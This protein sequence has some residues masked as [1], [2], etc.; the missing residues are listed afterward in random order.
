MQEPVLDHDPMSWA[1]LQIA[2]MPVPGT[3][4]MLSMLLVTTSKSD[5]LLD[6][7]VRLTNS[8]CLLCILH[9]QLVT[10]RRQECLAVTACFM[11]A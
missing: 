7:V 3:Q 8:R 6:A 1:A 4:A 10:D 2:N 11:T 5:G 9:Q